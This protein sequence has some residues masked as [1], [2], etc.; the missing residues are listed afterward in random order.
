MN[1]KQFTM[2]DLERKVIADGYRIFVEL[3]KKPEGYKKENYVYDENK[4][5]KWNR[6]HQEELEEEYLNKRHEF[7]LASNAK[8]T[9]FGLDVRK[10]LHEEYRLSV[11]HADMIASRA[12]E[13]G[14]DSGLLEVVNQA[15]DLAEFVTDII[16]SIEE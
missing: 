13:E 3:P 9:E 6:E 16:N 5:V 7:Q 10:A 1:N 4:T 2:E 8:E 14:H 11:K 12:W 15:R